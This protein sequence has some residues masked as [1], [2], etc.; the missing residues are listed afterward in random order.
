MELG[1]PQGVVWFAW[2]CTV[3]GFGEREFV[4]SNDKPRV[5]AYRYIIEAST[6]V[7]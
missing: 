4:T 3:L 6:D 7:S 5:V 2:G 1:R